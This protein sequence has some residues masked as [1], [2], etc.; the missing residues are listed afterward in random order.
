MTKNV[1]N[2]PEILFKGVC[3]T[4]MRHWNCPK[5]QKRLN[6]SECGAY[7]LSKN[8]KAYKNKQK[9]TEQNDSD[10]ANKGTV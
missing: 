10:K 2:Y 6:L 1:R 5:A 9:E 4:C 8:S 3:V 7:R